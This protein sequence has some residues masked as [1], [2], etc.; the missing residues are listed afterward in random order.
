MHIRM[1]R[2]ELLQYSIVILVVLV[3]WQINLSY[4][5]LWEV[6][7]HVMTESRLTVSLLL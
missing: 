5:Y 6:V 7:N 4:L 2:E 3:E 1:G